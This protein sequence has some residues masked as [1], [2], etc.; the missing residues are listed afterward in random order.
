MS[1]TSDPCSEILEFRVRYWSEVFWSDD[2]DSLAM[3]PG[4][5][6]PMFMGS[7]MPSLSEAVLPQPVSAIAASPIPARIATRDLRMFC[8]LI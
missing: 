1:V 5:I 8:S 2:I 4:S 6:D 3:D 7:A